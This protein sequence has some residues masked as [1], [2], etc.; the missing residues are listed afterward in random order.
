M[1]EWAIATVPDFWTFEGA[2]DD[3]DK[4]F[5]GRF[6]SIGSDIAM[7]HI[8]INNYGW[9]ISTTDKDGVETNQHCVWKIT[10]N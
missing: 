4:L 2:W 5:Y 10:L 3:E 9:I 1:Y 8:V 6:N 7:A